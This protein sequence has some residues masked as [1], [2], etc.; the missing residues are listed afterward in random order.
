MT[1]DRG[2]VDGFLN[3]FVTA[4]S[5]FRQH[6]QAGH[7]PCPL[8]EDGDLTYARITS[9][10]SELRRKRDGLN[11]EIIALNEKRSEL[12]NQL[13][14]AKEDA[15]ELRAEINDLGTQIKTKKKELEEPEI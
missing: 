3:L 7:V 12:E 9:K 8:C 6:K 14:K 1:E 13:S 11:T 15:Q 5:T 10:L 4:E 2:E